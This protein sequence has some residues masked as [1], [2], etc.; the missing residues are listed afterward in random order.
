MIYNW[1]TS[2]YERPNHDIFRHSP[3]HHIEKGTESEYLGT[4]PERAPGLSSDHQDYEPFLVGKFQPKPWFVTGIL[5]GRVVPMSECSTG[6]FGSLISRKFI[7]KL[8]QQKSNLEWRC[9]PR[10]KGPWLVGLY[11]GWNTTQ[12]YRDYNRPLS[13]S[14]LT[15]Q[16]NGKYS[17]VFFRAHVSPVKKYGDFPA[18]HVSFLEGVFFHWIIILSHWIIVLRNFKGFFGSFIPNFF[19]SN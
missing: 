10:K 4:T 8:W 11:R 12:L 18:S 7:R 5:G 6:I 15:N 19:W 9:E 14:Q 1:C 2:I 17:R 3:H 13:G 16:Y